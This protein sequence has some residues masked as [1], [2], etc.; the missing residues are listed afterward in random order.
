MILVTGGIEASSKK[1][2]IFT[3]TLHFIYEARCRVGEG[4]SMG[5]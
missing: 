3:G 5:M 1:T 4:L 2:V